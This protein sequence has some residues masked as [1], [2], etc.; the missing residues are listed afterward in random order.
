MKASEMTNEELAKTVDEFVN[1]FHNDS[2]KSILREAAARL[3]NV[4]I[5]SDNSAVIA[6]LQRR[7]KVAEDALEKSPCGE[8]DQLGLSDRNCYNWI[9]VK[10]DEEEGL[11][12]P[13]VGHGDRFVVVPCSALAAI[14]EEGGAS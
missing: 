7:L 13:R 6:E 9:A 14:R 3:R 5:R 2:D 11:K 10:F 4:I 8:V 12:L 1:A